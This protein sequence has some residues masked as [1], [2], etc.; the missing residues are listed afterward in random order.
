MRRR[1]YFPVFPDFIATINA[2]GYLTTASADSFVAS[3]TVPTGSRAAVSFSI[4][5]SESTRAA[6]GVFSATIPHP[7]FLSLT[8]RNPSNRSNQATA[9]TTRSALSQAYRGGGPCRFQ[10]SCKHCKYRKYCDLCA[11]YINPIQ[12]TRTVLLRR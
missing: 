7:V 12:I 4:K 1:I 9:S 6:H 11:H 2:V 10:S 8:N 3:T 5:I